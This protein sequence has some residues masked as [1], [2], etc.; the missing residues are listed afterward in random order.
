MLS[1]SHGLRQPLGLSKP[2]LS[3]LTIVELGGT[4]SHVQHENVC[5]VS[6]R[7]TYVEVG[8]SYDYQVRG[9]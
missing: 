9:G 2:R 7:P 4:H 8:A 3:S 1:E 6:Q 5:Y